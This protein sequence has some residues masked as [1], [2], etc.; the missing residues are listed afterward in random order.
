MYVIN[1]AMKFET[2]T[3]YTEKESAHDITKP[4]ISKKKIGWTQFLHADADKMCGHLHNKIGINVIPRSIFWPVKWALFFSPIRAL[5][6]SVLGCVLHQ[7][8]DTNHDVTL[9]VL[10]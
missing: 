6:R 10:S 5:L 9:C 1:F 3:L 8:D 2:K 4:L 7:P